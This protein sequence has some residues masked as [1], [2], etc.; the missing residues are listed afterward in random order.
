MITWNEFIKQEMKKPEMKKLQEFVLSERKEKK[1]YP[2]SKDVFKAFHLTPYK[3]VKCV[4]LGQDPYHAPFTAHGLAF[5]SLQSNTPL[6]LKKIFI[7]IMSDYFNGKEHEQGYFKS[8][9]LTEWAEQGVLLLN[10]V[11][12]VEHGKAGSHAGQGWEKFCSETIKLLNSHDK[13]LVFMLWGNQARGHKVLINPRKHL[14]LQAPHP[15]EAGFFGCKHFSQANAFI[16]KYNPRGSHVSINWGIWE[17]NNV[18][19]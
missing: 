7:E 5:S 18:N 19:Q 2:P 6:S 14:V 11:L 10:T 17:S 1:I 16:E 12:T 4:I 3:D 13:R 15:A 9:N 8:N